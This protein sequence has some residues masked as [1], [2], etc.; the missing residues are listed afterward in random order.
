MKKEE[1]IDE[2]PT[3]EEAL[4]KLRKQY[5]NEVIL[6]AND[7]PKK[8]ESIPT[9]CFAIDRLLGCGGIPVGRIIEVFSEPSAGK[10][11]LCLFFAAQVQKSGGMVVWIDAENAYEASYAKSIGVDTSKLMVSQ[12]ETLEECFD[13]I[14]ALAETK[15]IK[16]IVVD[17]VSALVPRS[18]L[19]GEEMLKDTYAVQARL[20]SKALRIITGPISRSGTILIFINQTRSKVGV[21]WG[22][23]EVSTGGK[24]LKFYSSVRLSVAK[25]DKIMGIKKDE[26][27]GNVVKITAVKN[28]V[29]FP[30]KKGSFDLYYGE[31]IDLVA[32]TLDTAEE[33][34]VIKKEGN[35]YSL[36]ETKLGVG[37]DKAIEFLKV[38]QEIYKKI[39]QLV[40]SVIKNEK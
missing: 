40:E 19:E 11:T 4:K 28:K 2:S 35:T 27:I 22:N 21:Y 9:N 1:I 38:D 17:S 15:K 24:A 23:P 18:E 36:G 33:L 8:I 32:D 20:L 29:G 16:L 14:R 10:S 39:H 3:I 13:T 5:G 12:S 25:G 31:G 7:T 26:Q 6:K 37:R 30:F 34:K